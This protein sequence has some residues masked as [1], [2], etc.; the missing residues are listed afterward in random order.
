MAFREDAR[1]SAKLRVVVVA[2]AAAIVVVVGTLWLV[3][4]A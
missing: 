3:Y 2:S 1:M 4:R